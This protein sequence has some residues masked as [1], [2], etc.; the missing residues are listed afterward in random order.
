ME[1]AP[2]R[3]QKEPAGQGAS[4]MR[5]LDASMVHREPIEQYIPEGAGEGEAPLEGAAVRV[6]ADEGEAPLEGAEE[7]V[8]RGVVLGCAVGEAALLGE[9]AAVLEER[10][11]LQGT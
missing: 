1:I 10:K 11:V 6:A 2:A 7:C 9:G 3:V 8:A 5:P 4:V